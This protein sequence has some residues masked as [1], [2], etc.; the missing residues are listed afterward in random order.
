[1]DLEEFLALDYL[2]RVDCE[3]MPHNGERYVV[4][5]MGLTAAGQRRNPCLEG[6]FRF[7]LDRPRAIQL[8]RALSDAVDEVPT[9]H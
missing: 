4:L 3:V 9:I 1:M 8:A 7:V 2:S 5:T 6:R